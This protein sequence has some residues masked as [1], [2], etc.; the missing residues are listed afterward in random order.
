VFSQ[1]MAV[2]LGAAAVL[3]GARSSTNEMPCADMPEELRNYGPF[4]DRSI[5]GFS[6][7]NPLPYQLQLEYYDRP[8]CSAVLISSKHAISAGHCFWDKT[9]NR[10]HPSMLSVRSGALY[11]NQIGY[12]YRKIKKIIKPFR[13]YWKYGKPDFIIMELKRPFTLIEGFVQPACLSS[14]PLKPGQ[15]CFASG[16]G[17]TSVDGTPG[18]ILKAVKMKIKEPVH[19]R[20][21]KSKTKDGKWNIGKILSGAYDTDYVCGVQYGGYVC[22][23]D[24][25]GP[26]VCEDTN[27]KAVLQGV[28]SGGLYYDCRWNRQGEYANVNKYNTFIKKNSLDKDPSYWHGNFHQQFD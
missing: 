18:T 11:R 19:C 20:K 28:V 26:M 27:G 25:G 2:F 7:H 14:K 24:S 17:H 5:G 9:E 16:W 4:L 12:E 8:L 13:G 6:L 10:R 15:Q 22:D 3:F 23:G 1:A 21:V